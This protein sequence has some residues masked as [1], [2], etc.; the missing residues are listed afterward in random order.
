M[1]HSIDSMPYRIAKGPRG[2]ETLIQND[3]VLGS[4]FSDT[5]LVADD[6]PRAPILGSRIERLLVRLFGRSGQGDKI[7]KFP[8]AMRQG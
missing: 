2:M 1:N 6:G 3:T 5:V 4:D 8:T 7:R